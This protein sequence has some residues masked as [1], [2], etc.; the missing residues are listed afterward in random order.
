MSR[1]GAHCTTCGIGLISGG[2]CNNSNC[3]KSP[4]WR[5]GG[6]KSANQSRRKVA[7]PQ[8]KNS[9]SWVQAGLILAG[10]LI[11]LAAVTDQL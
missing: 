10:I 7:K 9:L 6:K 5:P 8:K 1:E 2:Y 11:F 4:S 3:L